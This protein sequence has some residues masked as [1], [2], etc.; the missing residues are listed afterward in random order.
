[1][2]TV[3]QERS[4]RE[5]YLLVIKSSIEIFKLRRSA[6]R[7]TQGTGQIVDQVPSGV[8]APLGTAVLADG[9]EVE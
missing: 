3:E 7:H 4:I 6:V 1:M 8:T 2:Q 5:E 9:P